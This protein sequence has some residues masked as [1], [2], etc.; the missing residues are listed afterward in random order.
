MFFLIL[1]AAGKDDLI[2]QV[3]TKSL[4]P[5]PS[6]SWIPPPI[7]ETSSR[8]GHMFRNQIAHFS[9]D[10]PENHAYVLTAVSDPLIKRPLINSA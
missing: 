8:Q 5:K 9:E 4:N 6:P 10:T 3:A 7:K 2:A 1:K